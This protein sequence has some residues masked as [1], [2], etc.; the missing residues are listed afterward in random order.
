MSGLPSF[1]VE[2][3]YDLNHVVPVHHAIVDD[4]RRDRHCVD[5]LT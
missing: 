2:D 5:C 1:A 3:S 4:E